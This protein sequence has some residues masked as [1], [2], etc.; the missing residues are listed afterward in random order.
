MSESRKVIEGLWNQ[1]V[2]E[3]TYGSREQFNEHVFEQYKIFVEMA[4]RVSMRRNV[5]NTFFL[6]LHTFI[7]STISF[8]F[9]ENV[10]IDKNWLLVVVLIAV[11]LMCYVWYRVLLSYR[12]LNSAKFKVIGE[13]E[14]MLPS[15]PFWA[16]EWK[17]M[18][19]GKDRSLYWPLTDIEQYVPII[20]AILYLFGFLIILFL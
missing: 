11:L 19:E 20:F 3:E 8:L 10:M 7:I 16:A 4:D 18:G 13:F 6:S 5:A 2:N 12:Q 1:N 14:R 15:S 9:G 17:A